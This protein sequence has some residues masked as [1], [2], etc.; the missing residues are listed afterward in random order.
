MFVLGIQGSP[1][2]KGNTGFLLSAFMD[3]ARELG[4]KTDVIEVDKKNVLP[5]KEYLV[6]EKKGFCPIDDDMKHEIYSLLWEADVVVTATP[7]FFYNT[8]AQLKALIDR[9]QT[10]WARKYK[11]K[12]E[13]PGRKW[14]RGFLLAVGATRGKN[15]FEGVRLTTKYFMDAVGASFDGSLCYR[16]IENPGDLEKHP[17]VLKDVKEAVHGLLKPFVGRKKILFA[18]RENACRSQMASAFAQYVAGDKIEAF[19]G[20]THPAKSIDPVMAKAM[21]E[22]GIDMAF[23]RPKSLESTIFNIQPDI[24]IT[25]GCE[26][27]CSFIPEVKRD[28]WDLTDPAGKPIEVMRDLCD[29]I[30]KRVVKLIGQL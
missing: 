1:R 7:I 22:K 4:A 18:C 12:L 28:D 23:R 6:C 13:D 14:R 15:L 2:K 5:C 21:A 19:S 11:L 29:Q 20:G 9:C 24:V 27:E 16:Q 30:E 3:Q 8:P 26:E 25:M 17:T 10:L